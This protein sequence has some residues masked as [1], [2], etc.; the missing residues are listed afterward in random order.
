M[1]NSPLTI[2]TFVDHRFGENAY[3]VSTVDKDGTSVGW[4]IDPSFPPQTDQLLEYVWRRKI[5]VEKI[6]LTHGH[7]D[8]IAGVDIIR[9]AW[10]N[11]QLAIGP[12]DR[13]MLIDANRNLSAPFGLELTVNT[14]V[15]LD[16]TVGLE[17]S[18]GTLTWRVLDTRGHSPGG[19]SLYCPAAGVVFT[20]DAIFAGS[21]GRTDFPGSDGA[22]L[23]RNLR[24][25]LLTLPDQTR[26][27]SGHGPIT[28][29]G[30]ERK[31]NPFLA[32]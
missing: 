18:L 19:V 8:H 10:P 5:T 7:A 13:S 2:E 31:S 29:V 9:A 30:R 3:V 26:I 28:T 22:L 14:P 20:G 24:Q 4:V 23:I 6:V 11:A 16:L 12:G 15:D 17:L 27:Y 1:S 25:N 32:E 21:I